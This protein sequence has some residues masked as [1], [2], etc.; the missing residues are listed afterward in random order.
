MCSE[1]CHIG[2]PAA[3]A[4][5][6]A[7]DHIGLYR[8]ASALRRTASDYIGPY[9]TANER[10]AKVSSKGALNSVHGAAPRQAECRAG[11]GCEGPR[12]ENPGKMS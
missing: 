9:P 2:E 10:R 12:V 4:Y 11:S 8:T 7:P 1:D 6:V 5:T 3:E